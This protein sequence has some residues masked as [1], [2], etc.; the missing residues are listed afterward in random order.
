LPP[1]VAPKRRGCPPKRS[2]P[3]VAVAR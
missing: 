1:R 3:S 2:P